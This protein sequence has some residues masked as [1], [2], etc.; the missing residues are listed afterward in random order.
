MAHKETPQPGRQ[1]QTSF[2][3]RF[4]SIGVAVLGIV[5]TVGWT[6]L[7]LSLP[8][9]G[10]RCSVRRFPV[11]GCLVRQDLIASRSTLGEAESLQPGDVIL[12]A[13]GHTIEEWLH[14]I[15]PGQHISNQEWRVGATIP[16]TILREVE[17]EQREL[18]IPVRL[19]EF[20]VG[21]VLQMG[22]NTYLLVLVIVALTGFMVVRQPGERATH[23]LLVCTS[24]TAILQTHEVLDRE[25]SLL[26]RP[27]IFW[28]DWLLE[29]LTI[30]LCYCPLVHAFL[31]FPEKKTF[32][33]RRP[34]I[35]WLLYLIY[36]IF[37]IV[38]LLV[39]GST[40]TERLAFNSRVGMVGM[41]LY[42]V[43]LAVGIG[44][45]FFTARDP[46]ARNQIRW[47]AWGFAVGMTPW[48]FFHLLPMAL[49]GRSIIP[50]D[51][52]L[53]FNSSPPSR[54]SSPSSGT[55]CSTSTG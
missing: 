55:T 2:L 1:L 50:S 53:V 54:W 5:V 17:G 34:A 16:Y 41:V 12:A 43:V 27:A 26:V 28:S 13:G 38:G 3:A 45:S 11:P 19:I 44:H 24:A 47:I 30:W 33:Q 49:V 10:Y 48:V 18:T 22:R 35:L 37:P 20:P 39:G 9:D 52:A 51:L 4:W 6:A 31:I 32:I 40:W 29:E 46:K 23:L 21:G 36:P 15:L 14:A 8:T 42:F 25:F 7:R